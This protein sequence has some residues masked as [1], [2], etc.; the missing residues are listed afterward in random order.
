MP[1]GF[2]SGQ[3]EYIKAIANVNGHKTYKPVG[4]NRE[5]LPS[6]TTHL[7]FHTT[8]NKTA[9]GL[10]VLGQK[11]QV[12][13][14]LGNIGVDT[15]A[16][17][18]LDAFEIPL[19]TNANGVYV[20][21]DQREGAEGFLES[22]HLNLRVV[23]PNSQSSTTT[24]HPDH[25]EFRFIVFRARDRQHHL[26]THAK[27]TNNWLFNLFRGNRNH[28][29]GFSGYERKEEASAD[30]AYIL[31][32]TAADS[33]IYHVNSQDAMT[34]PI[35]KESYVVMQDHRFYLGKE[36]G[37]KNIYE[38][39]LHWDW[40]DPISTLSP[41]VTETDNEKNYVWYMLLIASNNSM[42]NQDDPILSVRITG[43]THMTSG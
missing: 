10:W 3:I 11:P 12:R 24:F 28:N 43:T 7:N 8:D 41:D 27:D 38:Q 37:G 5:A 25:V 42:F 33:G 14:H 26:M 35:N 2:N 23:L 13:D 32:S 40:K 36:Y 34:A 30:L 39:S 19:N 21:D 9:Y 17:H 1:A 31:N 29:I 18:E 6:A 22:T 15:A 20:P 4:Y 16:Y